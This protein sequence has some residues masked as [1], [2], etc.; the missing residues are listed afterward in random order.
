MLKKM[1]QL[2]FGVFFIFLFMATSTA[3]G[4]ED[5]IVAVVNNDVITLK[6][7]KEY[8]EMIKGELRIEGRDPVEIA[9]I[10]EQ[11]EK[12]G[13]NQLIEDRLILDAATA[14]GIEINKDAVER[15]FGEIRARYPSEEVFIT[16]LQ[17][18]GLSITDLRKRVTDKLKVKYTVD[19][20]VRDKVIVNPQE[21]TRFYKEHL[22]DL[23]ESAKVQLESVFVSFLKGKEVA[24][25]RASGAR[26]KLI[27]GKDFTEVSREY[28]ELPSVGVV[29][30][31]QLL[32]TV[33]AEV[34]ALK[35]NE[36]SSLIEVENGIY[37]FK[38]IKKSSGS[39]PELK[40]VKDRIY[41]KIFEDK[42]KAKFKTWLD[43]LKKEAY[44]EIKE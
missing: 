20:E 4:L 29:E 19:L 17:K 43:K 32:S 5:A 41:N 6:D 24:R 2:K 40:S 10:M 11:Y 1:R 14:K 31:G 12:K 28:S 30:E 37:V 13:I 39:I 3:F 15:R 35:E 42:F 27:E 21:V 23:K 22:D 34:F 25:Q 8:I 36:I 16:A 18:E 38:L 44:V 26:Q 7:L 9:E 33:E